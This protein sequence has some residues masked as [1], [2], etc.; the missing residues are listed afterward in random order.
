MLMLHKISGIKVGFVG[1]ALDDAGQRCVQLIK[2]A[3]IY[4]F[5]QSVFIGRLS[6]I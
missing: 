5:G 3:C 6:W 1:L 2:A 4:V